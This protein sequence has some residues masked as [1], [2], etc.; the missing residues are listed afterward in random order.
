MIREVAVDLQANLRAKGCLVDV[1][2]GPE[3]TNTV[4]FGRERI[5]IEHGDS[6]SFQPAW[7]QSVNPKRFMTRLIGAKGTIYSKSPKAGALVF[8]HRRRC[9]Q[10]LDMTLA[11]LSRVH[12]VRN[13][14]GAFLPSSGRFITPD[15]LAAS[16][17]P[18][19]AVYEF[20]FTIQRGVTDVT[21]T[22]DAQPEAEVGGVDGVGINNVTRVS[23]NGSETYESIPEV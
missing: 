1:V 4:T 12:A 16:E 20:T 14:K 19:G 5:V 10:I 8:E 3:A 2:V 18:G 23:V 21:W 9:E 6:D 13:G 17:R 11:A 15:D 7:S 22:G